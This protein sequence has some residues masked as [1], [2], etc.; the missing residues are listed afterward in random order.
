MRTTELHRRPGHDHDHPHGHDHDHPHGHDHDHPHGHDHGSDQG[1][2]HDQAT[3]TGWLSR[4]GGRAV[5][6]A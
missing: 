4:R 5:V 2:A 3:S 1:H 6:V